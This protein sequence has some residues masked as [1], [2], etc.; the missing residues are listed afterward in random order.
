[1]PRNGAMGPRIASPVGASGT[2]LGR[3]ACGT[4]CTKSNTD[5]TLETYYKVFSWS[6]RVLASGF[7]PSSDYRGEPWAPGSARA[8]RSGQPL[9]GGLRGIFV[10]VT[11]DAKWLKEA[12]QLPWNY[13]KVQ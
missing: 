2:G 1:M 6:M 11:G 4:V 9:A 7:H 5:R 13:A 10:E 8:L 3:L 12:L